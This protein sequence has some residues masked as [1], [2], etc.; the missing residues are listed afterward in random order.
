M[1]RQIRR[2]GRSRARWT[3]QGR[4]A[5]WWATP[6]TM[7]ISASVCAGY[8]SCERPPRGTAADQEERDMMASQEPVPGSNRLDHR[9]GEAY[10]EE[11]LAEGLLQPDLL[12]IYVAGVIFGRAADRVF[13]EE[14]LR[15]LGVSNREF[16]ALITLFV[17]GAKYRK[18]GTLADFLGMSAS[19]I[20][21]LV[22]RLE[23]RGLV[24]RALDPTDGRARL[25]H[26]TEEGL[27]LADAG[28]RIQL[29]WINDT[30][31]EAL[32]PAQVLMLEE[33]LV[34]VVVEINPTYEAP[35]IDR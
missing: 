34:R 33:L 25:I 30:I 29:K 24:E 10:L 32:T 3:A 4:K 16:E 2:Y 19:G 15:E 23:A 1:D 6:A 22:E 31:G 7:A 14:Y 35:P 5:V 20:T 17:W 27:R 26:P 28:L 12:K 11:L 18:P 21:A 8:D 13:D 9:A